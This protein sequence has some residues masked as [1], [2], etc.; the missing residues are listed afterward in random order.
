MSDY[1]CG[2]KAK[3]VIFSAPSGA[4]KTT[5]VKHLLSKPEFRFEF[6]ISAASRAAR[7]NEVDGKDYYFLGIDEFKKRVANNEFLEWEEVYEGNFYGTLK[8]EIERIVKRGNHPIFDVDVTGGLNIKKY[9]GEDALGIFVM[10]PTVDA[11]EKR[12]RERSTESEESLQK[13][14]NKAEHEM[15]YFNKFDKVILND[16][17]EHALEQA[18]TLVKDFLKLG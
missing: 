7:F 12:L 3:A 18:E 2:V 1:F 8:S 9:F 10:P 13:R 11:L 5:I 15:A 14:I 4:G 16:Q 6:S 17:L